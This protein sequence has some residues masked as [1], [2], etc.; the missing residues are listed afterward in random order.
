MC[1]IAGLLH[2]QAE[3]RK[4]EVLAMLDR[5]RHRG[6][7]DSGIWTEPGIALGHVRL[8]I[9]DL[10]DTGHQPLANE[11]QTI[12]VTLNGEIY[13]FVE[14]RRDLAARGHSFRGKSDTEIIPHLYEEYGDNFVD[15]LRGMFAIALWDSRKRRLLLA[16]DR[17][18]KKP[19]FLAPVPGGI[20]FASEIKALF[21]IAG[22]DFN[23]RDAGL[24][25]FLAAGVVPGARTIYRGIQRVRPGHVLSVEA[26]GE[27]RT[28]R[29][30]SLAFT[31][32]I[33]IGR[34]DAI[35]NIAGLLREAVRLRLRSDVDIGTFLSGGIDSGIITALAATESSRPLKTFSI[36]FETEGF[37]ERPLARLVAEKYGTDHHEFMV[38]ATETD[39]IPAIVQHF[40]EP[41]SDPSMLPSFAV[42]KLAAEHVKVVLNGDG[43][44]EVFAGYRH[45]V[46]ARLIGRFD[47]LGGDAL[48][49]LLGMFLRYL[50]P[51]RRGR[52]RYQ[53]LH[54]F[55]RTLAAGGEEQCAILTNDRLSHAEIDALIGRRPEPAFENTGILEVDHSDTTGCLGPVDAMLAFDFNRLLAD[56]HLVKM[57]R[58]SMAYT[59][60]AR[61]PFLDQEL[62]DYAARLPESLKL[63]GRVT[64][65]LLRSLAERY[66]PGELINA[67]KRGFEIPLERWMKA[68]LNGLLRDRLLDNAS[69][70]R[71]RFDR[72]AL[73]SLVDGKGWDSK[74]WAAIAW[75]LLCL[76]FWWDGHCT[77]MAGDTTTRQRPADT[78]PRRR[79]KTAHTAISARVSAPAT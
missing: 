7:D 59:I 57:D 63:P 30:W 51:P 5:L 60:E 25:S 4:G 42:S 14:L 68:D 58:A 66:L 43:A 69:F 11:D 28:R 23:I 10:A 62:I 15:H 78:A 61:S 1:G 55:L 32:K 33:Q 56:E 27:M 38:T 47:A 76:E 16:R 8:S 64:K 52:N 46:A 53:Y 41:F 77:R 36:G 22:A 44:D 65:P 29:Y 20:A 73:E 3:A 17:A 9:I 70:A 71:K 18:G 79:A 26:N 48:K 6:G 72:V 19:I 67:P 74:R 54:R 35:E 13:N 37:D 50:P 12:W 21:E 24:R 39:D 2:N 34:E 49:P 31:P 75:S 40:D 45:M